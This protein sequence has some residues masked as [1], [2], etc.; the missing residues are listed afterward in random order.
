MRVE[1]MT[2]GSAKSISPTRYTTEYF[3]SIMSLRHDPQVRAVFILCVKA[4]K[5]SILLMTFHY[6]PPCCLWTRVSTIFTLNSPV[7]ITPVIHVVFSVRFITI[8][9]VA[10]EKLPDRT[11][12]NP[13]INGTSNQSNVTIFCCL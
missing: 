3:M 4:V 8:P 6:A 12:Q 10:T 1:N 5:H 2:S 9:R 13:L 7:F 11:G